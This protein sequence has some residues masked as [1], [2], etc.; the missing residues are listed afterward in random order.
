MDERVAQYLRLDS[1]LIWPTARCVVVVVSG[2]GVGIPL[3]RRRSSITPEVSL[4]FRVFT[5]SNAKEDDDDVKEDDEVDEDDDETDDDE[6]AGC[7]EAEDDEDNGD[8]DDDEED[9]DDDDAG[10]GS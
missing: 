1:W 5:L 8:D 6:N 2:F 9:D 3:R 4:T 10:F 7:R